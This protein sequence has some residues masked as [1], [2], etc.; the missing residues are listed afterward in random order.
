LQIL[1]LEE[2]NDIRYKCLVHVRDFVPG[3][4]IY[5]QILEAV[6][7]SS[8]TVI[9][10]SKNYVTSNWAMQEFNTAHAKKKVILVVYGEIPKEVTAIYPI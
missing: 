4:P 7:S 6:E 5:E 8:R 1:G 9:V 2:S 3:R 10:L